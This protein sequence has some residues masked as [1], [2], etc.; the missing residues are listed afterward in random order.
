MPEMQKSK[1]NLAAIIGRDNSLN[2]ELRREDLAAAI[3][4][5]L[6]GEIS[7]VKPGAALREIG[8]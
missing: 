6:P 5:L 1:R 8:E 7:F 4:S 3:C 2:R